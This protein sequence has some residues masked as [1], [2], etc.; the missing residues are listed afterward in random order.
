MLTRFETTRLVGLRAL[1][2]SEG[3][4]PTVNVQHPRLRRDSVYVASLELYNKRMDAC[5]IRN[6]STVHVS[7]LS[8]PPDLLTMLNTRDGLT[9]AYSSLDPTL[10][11]CTSPE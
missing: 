4:E 6:G 7:S 9:R 3:A 1:Q 10:T 11:A 8:F 2:I 5:V